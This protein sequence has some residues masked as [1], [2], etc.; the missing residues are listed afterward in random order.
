MN[1]SRKS[2][3]LISPIISF[4]IALILLYKY[5]YPISW[6][7]YYHIHMSQLYL[8]EGLIFKDLLTCYPN[9]R[10]IMYPPLFHLIIA[11]ISRL[12][13][14]TIV[15]VC[16]LLQP[17]L[18]FY[19]MGIITYSTYKLTNKVETAFLSGFIAMLCF[20]T[21]NRSVITTPAT[22]A[23]GLS[24]IAC[25][26]YFTGFRDNNLREIIISA[27]SLGLIWN[28]HMATAII[29][30]G[31]IGLYTIIQIIR[32]K[33]NYRNLIYFIL[34]ALVIAIPWWLYI[35]LNYPMV[36]NSTGNNP[37]NIFQFLFAYF[38]IIPSILSII[39]FYSF[40]KNKSE[41]GL[42]L[43]IWSLSIIGLSQMTFFG[44]NTISIRIL[45]VGAY[46][47]VIIAS[48][49]FVYLCSLINPKFIKI[50]LVLLIFLSIL[51]SIAYIDSYTPN[52]LADDD[53]N[54]TILSSNYHK[55]IDPVGSTIT[56]SIISDRYGSSTL[57]HDRYD[58]TQWFIN[59][60]DTSSLLVCED[61]IM[62]TIIVSTSRTPVVYGGF[63]ES[64]PD[65][66]IDPVHIVENHSTTQEIQDTNMGYLLLDNDTPLP[67]YANIEY[68]NSNYKICSIKNNYR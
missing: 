44:V 66:V 57:A 4:C 17:F 60:N 47:L 15:E 31:V 5:S 1:I 19:L 40:Y 61:S 22:V 21:F 9:G 24:I 35:Y 10:T 23:I 48:I 14:I 52:L 18:S 65:T 62:D 55:I 27:I 59:N 41:M 50:L 43:S 68:E 16:R 13:H 20:A 63:T 3:L 49:G 37:M 29:A 6:D 67:I 56:P 54:N 51:S 12:T 53:Y 45:E 7:V 30:V 38:G 32:S 25:T 11:G 39:G 46:P 34:V 58:V 28:F 8:D 64:I 33:I 2:L 42:F 36:F 26:F